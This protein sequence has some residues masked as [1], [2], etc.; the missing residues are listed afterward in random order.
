MKKAK[1][2]FGYLCAASTE[3]N[4]VLSFPVFFFLLT[5]LF[6]SSLL[7]YISIY[8]VMSDNEFL[9]EM[10]PLTVTICLIGCTSIF[11]ILRSADLPINQVRFE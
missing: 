10:L 8:G 5:R 3:L 6:L 7:M 4:T 11:V 1:E 2:I 9:K